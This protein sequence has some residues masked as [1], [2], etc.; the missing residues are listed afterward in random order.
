MNHCVASWPSSSLPRAL[1]RR[2]HDIDARL[3]IA[4]RLIDRKRRGDVLVERGRGGEFAG[5][6]LDAAL[7]AEARKA[8]I[9]S[10]I[11]GNRCRS[12]C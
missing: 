6:D 9:C 10:A 1:G 7:V 3:Q 4:E 5:P 2:G 12:R 11:A 8:G